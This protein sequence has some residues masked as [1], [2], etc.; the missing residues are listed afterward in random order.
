MKMNFSIY[1]FSLFLVFLPFIIS[2]EPFIIF[3]FKTFQRDQLK[4][5]KE[6]LGIDFLKTFLNNTIYIELNI[7][8]PI[9]QIPTILASNDYSFYLINRKCFIPSSFD[10]VV[11]SKSYLVDESYINNTYIFKTQKD[12]TISKDIFEIELRDSYNKQQNVDVLLNFM[13]SPND[14][15]NNPILEKKEE[16]PFSDSINYPYTCAKLGIQKFVQNRREYEKNFIS[17]LAAKKFI[18]QGVFSLQYLT[19]DTGIFLIGTEPHINN[20]KEFLESRLRK[21]STEYSDLSES[22]I[23][24]PDKIFFI[25]DNAQYNITTMTKCSLE[26]DLGV[27]YGPDEYLK[28][29]QNEFFNSLIE[30]NQCFKE[31]IYS[32]Y[33]IFYCNEA[34]AIKKFPT[35]NLNINQ[36]MY[37]FELNYKDLFIKKGDKYFFNIIFDSNTLRWKLGKPFLKKYTFTYNYD[38]KT[39]GFYIPNNIPMISNKVLLLILFIFITVFGF[40]GFHFGKRFYVKIAKRRINELE[41]EY[42]YNGSEEILNKVHKIIEMKPK[43]KILWN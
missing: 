22:W 39:I 35:L 13:Y 12:I 36:L 1:Y 28:L 15:E 33:T 29:I 32:T 27:I 23:I 14:L 4:S 3:P 21:V 20:G 10:S 6:I 16:F 7:G 5:D 24:K 25:K 42:I 30:Q 17:Q 37:K 38:D 26:Y 43:Y 18:N 41:D 2:L 19:D 9:R 40:I 11:N 8:T 34:G 31:V